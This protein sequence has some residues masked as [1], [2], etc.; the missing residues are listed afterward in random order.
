MRAIVRTS[1]GSADVLEV[2]EVERPTIRADEVLVRVCAAGLDRGV[3]HLMT[4]TP[5]LLRL[6]TGLRAPR[7]PVL[8]MD[9]AGV[10]ETV[11][12]RVTEVR[13]GDEVFGSCSGAFAEY[14]AVRADRCAPKPAGLGFEQ[15]AALPTSATTALQALRGQGRIQPGQRVLVIG[16]GG[17]VG[18]YAVQLAKVHDAQV[19]GVCSTAKVQLVRSLGAD[20]V[21]D[22]TQQELT[23]RYDLVLDIAGN[24]TLRRLR[25]LLTPRGTLVIVG[26]EGGGRWTGGLGRQFRAVLWSV[27]LRQ[28]MKFFMT[29]SRRAD[30]LTLRELV[31]DGRVTPALDRTAALSEVPQAM[32]DLERGRVRGKVAVSL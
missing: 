26:G 31:E 11:G 28:R 17:G 7:H 13:T 18:T 25:R 19:T 8:G 30:L 14:A 5:Y 1:Y 20:E 15:A 22:Y 2:A 10:V 6:G 9:L 16:A 29:I 4:G 21:I 3:W 12:D 23:G 27:V 32:R 24:R